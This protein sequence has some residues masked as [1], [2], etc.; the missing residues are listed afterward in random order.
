MNQ[1][2]DTQSSNTNKRKNLH[3]LKKALLIVLAVIILLIAIFLVYT[4]QYYHAGT[5]AEAYIENSADIPY[6]LTTGK[7]KVSRES[8][9]LLFDGPGTDT[10]IIF[11]P[12]AKVQTEAYAPIM[13]LLAQEGYDC[14]LV[15]MPFHLA[16]FG[17][18]RAEEIMKDHLSYNDWY[19]AGHSLGGAMA[20]NYAAEHLDEF[21]GVIFL[22]AYP[23]KS[24]KKDGFRALSIY[25]SMDGVLNREHY[26]K[27]K[28]YMPD[29]FTEVVIQGGNHGQ[30]GDYGHQ[31]GDGK[32][33]ISAADQWSQT[34]D[35][36]D[37]FMKKGR[38]N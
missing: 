11:Y 1:T 35:A 29:D 32:A 30:F 2:A 4:S 25:G 17:M 20:G 18:N 8:N 23:T 38:S 16:F 13:Y 14:F 33:G 28:E 15:D 22:A 9:F 3:R 31:K 27:Y 34:A 7:V 12:G 5:S 24:L 26:E 6:K 37:Q 10:A 19:M 21:K 36:V